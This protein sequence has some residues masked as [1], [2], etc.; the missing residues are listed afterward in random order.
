M[1]AAWL[2]QTIAGAHPEVSIVPDAVC[3]EKPNNVGFLR[4]YFELLVS[5][6][7]TCS[8]LSCNCF[9]TPFT[10]D[11]VNL[12]PRQIAPAITTAAIV[13]AMSRMIIFTS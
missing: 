2:P 8:Q 7:S 12:S 4:A 10:I 13:P 6:L 11:L 5:V 1:G 3:C 9:V